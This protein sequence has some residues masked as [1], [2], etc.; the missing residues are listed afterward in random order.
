MGV[1]TRR[2]YHPAAKHVLQRLRYAFAREFCVS[3]SPLFRKDEEHRKRK[4]KATRPSLRMINLIRT[5]LGQLLLFLLSS[6]E[7]AISIVIS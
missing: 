1:C 2:N 6:D 5:D 3:E 7:I 4:R